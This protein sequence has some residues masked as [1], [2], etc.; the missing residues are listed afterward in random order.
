M[1][2]TTRNVLCLS[3]GG[4]SRFDCND[5]LPT[6][7]SVDVVDSIEFAR[8]VLHHRNFSVGLLALSC[9][10]T[11]EWEDV[12]RFLEQAASIPWVALLTEPILKIDSVRFLLLKHCFDYLTLPV[13]ASRLRYALGHAE[14]MAQLQ[15]HLQ[16]P[17]AS[18]TG[19]IG[20][21][22]AMQR[23]RQQIHK[24]AGVD[25]PVLISGESGSGKE[26]TARA[27]HHGSKRATGPFVAVNCG[28]IPAGLVQS[29]LFGHERGAFTGAAKER[30]GW[31]ESADHGTLFLD[32]IA[33]L[34]LDQQVNL[35][36]FLQE[37]TILRLGASRP[38]QVNVRVVA[39]SH[40]KLE[41]AVQRGR[42]REDLMYRLNVL[43][44]HV[45]ALRERQSDI[46]LLADHFFQVFAS[47]KSQRLTGWSHAAMQA[48]QN[49]G[50]PGNVRE[51]M[52]RIRRAMVMAEGR[53]ISPHDL[54]LESH[55]LGYLP[56]ADDAALQQARSRAEL[57]TIVQ[58]WH[59]RGKNISHA[60]RDLGV[61]RM[62][63]Y[64]LLDKHQLRSKHCV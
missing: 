25:A 41:D 49:H 62:T 12:D 6:V 61:S 2:V 51:F 56:D 53:L 54:G 23:L 24:V 29:E 55:S 14:G 46:P 47:E 43:P 37:G 33:D 17:F 57:D 21:S 64:R 3:L 28:A 52:N 38:V 39:A 8:Q 26:L 4:I 48:M 35:L 36:R 1:T 50:W 16:R 60:A 15:N 22:P 18:D 27:I 10:D 13:D 31:I 59:K 20:N 5:A 63:L 9:S 34:P 32:E 58:T 45:P 40:V 42:F 7:W 44:L 19:L 11:V 30:R